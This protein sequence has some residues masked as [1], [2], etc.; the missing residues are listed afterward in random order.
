[1]V[2]LVFG[3]RPAENKPEP[4]RSRP[5]AYSFRPG[6]YSFGVLPREPPREPRLQ[7]RQGRV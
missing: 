7:L 1:V 5:G 2:Y 6:A 3:T 4:R